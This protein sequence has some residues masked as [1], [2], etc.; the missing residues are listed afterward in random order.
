[1]VAPAESSLSRPDGITL[2]PHPFNETLQT[3]VVRA[4]SRWPQTV[5][6]GQTVKW[7]DNTYLA[8]HSTGDFA[9]ALNTLS[10]VSVIT[11]GSGHGKP[12]VRG[13]GFNRITYVDDGL[14]QEGQQWDA[15]RGLEVDALDQ[16][17]V[18]VVKGAGSFLYGSDAPG[19]VIVRQPA[20]PLHRQ[21]LY[22]LCTLLRQ[23][24]TMGGGG[25]P[26]MD[27]LHGAHHVRLHV[28]GQYYDDRNVTADSITY[29]TRWTPIYDR[30][31]KDSA[32]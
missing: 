29:F 28:S 30:R 24:S 31:L 26:M 23:N 21:G 27:Y 10:G 11:I 20:T 4:N 17:P 18:Q 2:E 5:R 25:S 32:T 14:K 7:L 16:D 3:V 13:P 9:T 15:D 8:K 19:G 6:L 1:M 12:V 22:G